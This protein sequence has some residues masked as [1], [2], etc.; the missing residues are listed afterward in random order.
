[1]KKTIYACCA[2]IW[3]LTLAISIDG[4]A[5]LSRWQARQEQRSFERSVKYRRDRRT[6]IC[7]AVHRLGGLAVVDHRHCG[8]KQ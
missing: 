7:F 1:M 6:G 3:M 5:S 4:C 8:R 2:M